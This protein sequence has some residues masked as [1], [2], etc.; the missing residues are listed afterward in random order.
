MWYLYCKHC[1]RY[2]ARYT[3]QELVL[4]WRRIVDEEPCLT[5]ANEDRTA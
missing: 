5:P 2:L 4:E 3:R 1:R